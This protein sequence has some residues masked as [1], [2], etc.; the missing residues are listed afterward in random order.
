MRSSRFGL[1]PVTIF[2]TTCVR[3]L[4]SISGDQAFQ[5]S[6]TGLLQLDLKRDGIRFKSLNF[7]VVGAFLGCEG[8]EC[9]ADRGTDRVDG[10]RGSFAEQVL[11]HGKDLFDRIQVGRVFWQ[12]EQFGPC[13]SM[14]ASNPASM[15][16]QKHTDLES[17]IGST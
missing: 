12:E 14:L 6:R 17:Q 5:R 8:I 11:E 4:A 16:N 1:T 15:V 13:L 2:S 3:H 7:E 10:S 9:V